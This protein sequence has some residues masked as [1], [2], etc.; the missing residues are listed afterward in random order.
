MMASLK[1]DMPNKPAECFPLSHLH[2]R[3]EGDGLKHIF[4]SPSVCCVFF[5]NLLPCSFLIFMS[6]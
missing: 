4:K 5:K 6:Y 1:Q 2:N 3:A